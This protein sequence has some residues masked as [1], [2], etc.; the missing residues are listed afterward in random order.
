M[1]SS[2]HSLSP[3]YSG[4]CGFLCLVLLSPF[5]SFLFLPTHP[6][7]LLAIFFFIRVQNQVPYGNDRAAQRWRTHCRKE[8]R[9]KVPF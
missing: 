2:S 6:S 1:L 9:V 7:F 4:A 5:P 8:T 3:P